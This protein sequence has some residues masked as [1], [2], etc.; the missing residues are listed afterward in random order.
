MAARKPKAEAT[1]T[2]QARHA[3]E[4]QRQ[5]TVNAERARITAETTAAQKATAKRLADKPTDSRKLVS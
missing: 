4:T 2:V 3:A 1:G 5:T